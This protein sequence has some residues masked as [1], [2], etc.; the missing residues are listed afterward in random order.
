MY[1][2]IPEKIENMSVAHLCVVFAHTLS[3]KTVLLK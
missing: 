3:P 1:L 2:C